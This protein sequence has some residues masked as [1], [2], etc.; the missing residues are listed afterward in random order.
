MPLG[1]VS[2]VCV[3]APSVSLSQRRRGREKGFEGPL[4][5]VGKR[6][7]SGRREFQMLFISGAVGIYCKVL[8]LE[9]SFLQLFL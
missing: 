6:K 2:A 3:S 7:F 8:I 1:K 5:A 9:I 4:F